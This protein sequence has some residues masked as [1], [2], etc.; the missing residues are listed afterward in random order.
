MKSIQN[1]LAVWLLT[2]VVILF[3]L[4]W[5][6]TSR[7]PEIFT[8]EYIATRLEHDGE[9]L[10]SG[11]SFAADGVPV[12][13]PDYI[14]PIYSRP[15]SGHY[16]L[17]QTNGYRLKSASLG[18]E[19]FGFLPADEPHE[20]L[21]EIQGPGGQPI[22]V[23]VA[24]FEKEGYRIN[25]V[26]AEELSSLNRSINKFRIRFLLV[27]LAILGLLIFVQRMIVRLSLR[28]LDTMSKA[29]RQLENG[30]ISKFPEDVPLEVKPLVTEINRLVELSRKRLIRSRNSLGNLA[31]GLKTPLAVLGQLIDQDA[32]KF[33][34]G[35]LQQA[36][37]SVTMI[38]SI[39]DREL[40]QARLAGP[41]SAGQLF[42]LNKELPDLLGLLQQVYADKQLEY[43]LVLDG[44]DMRFGEREDMLELIGNLLDNASKWSRHKVRF[45][46][47][48]DG[49][50][51][52][53]V[54]DDGPGIET[55]L[56][57][58]LM[59]RG[60]RLDETS[61][62]HGLGLSIVQEIVTQYAGTI[63]FSRSSALGGL[64]VRIFLPESG[65]I[66]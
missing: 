55:S 22:L 52:I 19:D 14:A 24:H 51:T 30:D 7:A 5:L 63:D 41:T 35:N 50:L 20:T 13:D 25:L 1:R 9:M 12:L 57:A 21:F 31:H 29:C 28:P 16:Y 65:I 4:H 38:Q 43:E 23:Q 46:A 64:Q 11:I 18:T 56:Q 47:N 58:S 66:D 3:G 54:A 42:H 40:K 33:S 48:T 61:S 10:Q 37:A 15:G 59:Q 36:K 32:G 62:G 53:S 6:V 27:T 45:T 44:D 49:G 39:I 17:L 26:I 34:A 2:S 8:K 60:T